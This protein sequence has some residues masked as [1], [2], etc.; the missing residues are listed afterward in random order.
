MT[1][2]GFRPKDFHPN[3]EMNFW[4]V[5]N[6]RPILMMN[7][8]TEYSCRPI[9][10]MNFLKACSCRSNVM[11]NCCVPEASSCRSAKV[12]AT[13]RNW[14]LKVEGRNCNE[15]LSSSRSTSTVWAFDK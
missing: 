10:M 14:T 11:V 2:Y 7:S 3:L 5:K 15:V 6:F 8:S 13:S 9:L 12:V 1:N 4:R